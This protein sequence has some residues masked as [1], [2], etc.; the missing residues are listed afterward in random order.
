MNEYLKTPDE[1][2]TLVEIEKEW[3]VVFEVRAHTMRQ[4]PGEISFPGGRLEKGETPAEAAVRETWPA[5]SADS[6][7]C[8]G[9]SGRDTPQP[10]RLRTRPAPSRR[11]PCLECADPTRIRSHWWRTASFTAWRPAC[12]AARSASAPSG[13]R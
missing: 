8:A 5:C 3:H 11:A 9:R 10:P 4:Q 13:T 2:H 7:R 12:R 6:D 1:I